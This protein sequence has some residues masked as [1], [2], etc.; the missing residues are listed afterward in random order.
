MHDYCCEIN[1]A[2]FGYPP[3]FL[4]LFHKVQHQYLLVILHCL[5]MCFKIYCINICIK[6]SSFLSLFSKMWEIVLQVVVLFGQATDFEICN[7]SV[8]VYATNIATE[9]FD[10]RKGLTKFFGLHECFFHFDLILKQF[11]I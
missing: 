9:C 6:Q 3:W 10:V 1:V 8:E 11:E 5:V 7:K 4:T 2:I